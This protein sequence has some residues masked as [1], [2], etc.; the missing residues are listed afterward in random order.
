MRLV[1]TT[2][3]SRSCIASVQSW[4]QAAER[5]RMLDT[6]HSAKRQPP[7]SNEAERARTAGA[8][9]RSQEGT[10]GQVWR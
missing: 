1:L 7:K 6:R 2:G 9:S 5:Q 3:S 10:R 8:A 4:E